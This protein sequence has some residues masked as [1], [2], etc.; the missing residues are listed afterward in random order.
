MSEEIVVE[1]VLN[2]LDRIQRFDAQDLI[3][4][5][6]LGVDFA[7]DQ[8][9]D[10]ARNLIS[11][12]KKLPIDAVLEFP[13][14]QKGIIQ[15]SCNGVWNIFEEIKNFNPRAADAEGHHTGLLKSLEAAYQPTFNK[16]F[17]LVSFAMA[18][19]VDFNKL[20]E[21]GRSA[22]QSVR[23]ETA[24]VMSDLESTS[25][26]AEVV[27][28]EVRNAAAKQGVTQQAKY[29]KNEAEYHSEQA[30]R[31]MIGLF[32]SSVVVLLYGISSLFFRYIPFLNADTVA[33]AIQLTVSKLL[34]FF[35]LVFMVLI[36][37]RNFNAHKHN[38]IV[39]KHR[40]NALMTFTTLVEAGNSLE[41]REIVLQHAAAAIYAPNDTGYM[42]NEER[43]Y[44]SS[45][46]VSVTSKLPVAGLS[47]AS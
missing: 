2:N 27:L 17:P 10:P 5:D 34:V 36:F 6:K 16:L 13:F 43:G 37:A 38:S 4:R 30:L 32:V 8:A 40:Q 42:K 25:E 3:Q 29:F 7:F 12:F 23:D 46:P 22:V 19:T 11:L 14:E 28:E 44:A 21:D 41:T 15:N 33:G 24:K 26:R 9:V 47:E 1:D 20:S 45:L 35:I 31:W 18:R 39:N